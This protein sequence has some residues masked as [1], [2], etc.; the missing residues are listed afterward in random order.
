MFTVGPSFLVLLLTICLLIPLDSTYTNSKRKGSCSYIFQS[1][2]IQ[3]GQVIRL[4][5]LLGFQVWAV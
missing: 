3:C 1:V 5:K 2:L 4:E